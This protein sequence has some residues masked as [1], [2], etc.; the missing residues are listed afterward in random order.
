MRRLLVAFARLLDAVLAERDVVVGDIARPAAVVLEDVEPRAARIDQQRVLLL[1][2]QL[3]HVARHAVGAGP[4]ARGAQPRE[5]FV[6]QV[7][8]LLLRHGLRHVAEGLQ[9]AGARQ[10]QVAADQVGEAEIR[11]SPRS[12][13]R[14][15]AWRGRAGWRR[16]PREHLPRQAGPRAS[17]R[18]RRRP[19]SDGATARRAA[20]ARRGQARRRV[21]N[22]RPSP[23]GSASAR[24]LAP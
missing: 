23:A 16:S 11:M 14:P 21:I 5:R 6:A 24:R 7:F 8:D 19:L 15:A 17:R 13:P 2:V 18:G 3:Q 4:V 9:R 1:G 22:C 10:Q 12:A 20:A